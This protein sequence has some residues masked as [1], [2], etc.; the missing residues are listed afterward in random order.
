MTV[1]AI[2]TSSRAASCAVLRD[3]ALLGEFYINNNLTHSQTILPMVQALLA[4]TGVVVGEI[5]YFAVAVG[6]G[7]FTGLRIGISA[8]KGMAMAAD[9]PC[10]AV[11][12]LEALAE[13]LS[14]FSGYIIPVMDARRSQVYT[15]LFRCEDGAVTRLRE[16]SAL[17]VEQVGV[18]VAGELAGQA[19]MLVGDGAALCGEKLPETRLRLAPENLRHQRAGSVARVALRRIAGGQVCS[20]AELSPAYLRLPQAERERLAKLQIPRQ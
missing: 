1:L 18:L 13:N 17:P 2:D 4:S 5:D 14:A 6:P 11:P 9:R 20:A 8:V 7:S 10:V 16:D 15:A 12:T 3:G 19:V